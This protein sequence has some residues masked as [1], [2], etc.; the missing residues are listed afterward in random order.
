MELPCI[1]CYLNL[2]SLSSTKHLHF[3]NTDVAFLKKLRF[4]YVYVYSILSACLHAYHNRASDITD[5][6]EP[7]YVVS[8]N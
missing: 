6:C 3:E 8:G 1:F 4:I 5:G 2:L 7:P